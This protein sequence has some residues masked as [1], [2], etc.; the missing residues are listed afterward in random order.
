MIEKRGESF[1]QGVI[2]YAFLTKLSKAL[3]CLPHGHMIAKLHAYGPDMSS[4]RLI[5]SYLSNRK[6]RVKINDT[7]IVIKSLV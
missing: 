5:Y 2:L 4:S 6:Q 1:D 7:Y 3:N